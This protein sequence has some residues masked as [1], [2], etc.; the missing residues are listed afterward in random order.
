[1]RSKY[2]VLK[3]S[4]I[5]VGDKSMPCFGIV[6]NLTDFKNFYPNPVTLSVDDDIYYVLEDDGKLDWYPS[7]LYERIL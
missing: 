5:F 4:L 3:S 7:Y 2:C 6:A 1:M